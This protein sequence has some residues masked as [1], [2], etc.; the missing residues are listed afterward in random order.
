MFDDNPLHPARV[1]A[2]TPMSALPNVELF[3]AWYIPADAP[4]PGSRER[5]AWE[6]AVPSRARGWPALRATHDIPAGDE[7]LADFGSG[8]IAAVATRSAAERQ[9]S[10][11]LRGEIE[12][13]HV[14]VGDYKAMAKLIF[15]SQVLLTD[16]S[17][18]NPVRV[19]VCVQM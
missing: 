8:Y 18:S 16:L 6:G 3:R 5:L 11:G 10:S 4:A 2:A 13:G 12:C 14:T 17:F 9:I 15:D 1:L 7:L 19:C